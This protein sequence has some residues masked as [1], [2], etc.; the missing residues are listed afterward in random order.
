MTTPL[1]PCPF[2]GGEAAF[3]RKGTPKQST[4]VVC[5]ACLCTLESGETFNHGSAWNHR[6]GEEAVA[7]ECAKIVEE[8]SGEYS[9]GHRKLP[10][11][12]GEAKAAEIRKRFGGK[13]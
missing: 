12:D 6:P 9:V 11:W 10:Y 13:A 7:E 4:I 5:D 1:K 3:D 2:C 8:P